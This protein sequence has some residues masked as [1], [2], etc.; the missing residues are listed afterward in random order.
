MPK[1]I[2]GIYNYCDRWCERCTFTSRCAVYVD[3]TNL[4]P[5]EM[6]KQNKAFWDRIGNNLMKAQ[7]LLQKAAEHFRVDLENLPEEPGAEQEKRERI[8]IESREHPISKLT[9][10]YSNIARGWLKTQP[11]MLERLDNLKAEL[12]MGVES[13]QG[14]KKQ[15]NTIKD[16]LSVIQWYMTFIHVKLVRAM[17]GKLKDDGWDMANG[18]Q[19]DCD[20]SAKIALIAIDRS[21]HAWTSLFDILPEKEDEFLKIL[22]MLEKIKTMVK[23]EFPKAEAFMR[24]GFD[25]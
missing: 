14:A 2:E 23:E 25:G 22:A 15:T 21:M 1:N 17:M 11:G 18:F 12:S 7:D 9:F 6:D 3:E 10:Q 20:G 16:S 8:K 5:E 24:P 19:R 13:T 4:P